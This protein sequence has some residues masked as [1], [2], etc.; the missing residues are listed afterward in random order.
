VTSRDMRRRGERQAGRIGRPPG[1]D[2]C[3]LQAAKRW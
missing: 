2:C 3:H 1:W